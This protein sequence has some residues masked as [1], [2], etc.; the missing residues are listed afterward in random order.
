MLPRFGER[1][2]RKDFP[3]SG[4]SL[5]AAECR[6]SKHCS[7]L[8]NHR[9]NS[10]ILANLLI[11]SGDRPLSGL[12]ASTLKV[13][14]ERM[15][16][17][18]IERSIKLYHR[19][20]NNPSLKGQLL[21]DKPMYLRPRVPAVRK[22]QRKRGYTDKGTLAEENST[23]LKKVLNESLIFLPD[24]EEQLPRLAKFVREFARS[25]WF[26]VGDWEDFLDFLF[27]NYRPS[28]FS[29]IEDELTEAFEEQLE[30]RLQHPFRFKNLW[31]DI[32][33]ED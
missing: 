25:D 28:N 18:E 24:L 12:E 5:L 11:T 30:F 19:S 16:I 33:S 23:V 4:K 29:E 26:S 15:S 17:E 22:P 1:F 21:K 20:R 8:A 10:E 3:N 7:D 9:K 31:K 2:S 14:S 13:L 32:I 27:E 6:P